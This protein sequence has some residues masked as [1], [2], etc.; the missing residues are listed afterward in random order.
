MFLIGP[1]FNLKWEIPSGRSPAKPPIRTHVPLFP[2]PHK[3][4]EQGCFAKKW[5]NVP[6]GAILQAH[7]RRPQRVFS[8]TRALFSGTGSP[9]Q[10]D[11]IQRGPA[12]A[13]GGRGAGRIT[14]GADMKMLWDRLRLCAW[15]L[16][17]CHVWLPW[18]LYK[19]RRRSRNTRS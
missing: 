18:L 1:L 16:F 2:Q 12:T 3:L 6:P 19:H 4:L 5:A 17:C 7:R 10:P 14:E 8:P 9:K 15:L 11:L 13:K